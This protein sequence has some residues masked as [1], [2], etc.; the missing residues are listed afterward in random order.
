MYKIS[1]YTF[2]RFNFIKKYTFYLPRIILDS[3]KLEKI[4]FLFPPNQLYFMAN[5]LENILLR[6]NLVASSTFVPPILL[7]ALI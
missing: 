3:N 4:N 5:L 1:K 7:H 2:H 6:I